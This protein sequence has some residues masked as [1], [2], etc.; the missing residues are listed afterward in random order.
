MR[1]ARA[2]RV[3]GA[4]RRSI[5][6]SLAALAAGCGPAIPPP[7][8]LPDLGPAPP[9]HQAVAAPAREP[10][11][12]DE[13]TTGNAEVQAML[14]RVSAARGL[15][16]RRQVTTRILDRDRI[17]DRI[18][19]KVEAE[20]PM[21]VLEHQGEVLAA[22]GL[23]PPEYDYVDG[24][25][26]LIQGR[27][28]GYYDPADDSMVLVDDLDEENAV[29]TLAHELVHALQDQAFGIDAMIKYRP[30]AGDEIAA[31]HSLIE[32]DATSAMFEVVLGSAF[33]V[34]DGA[35]RTILTASSAMSE[36]G[37]TPKVLQASLNAPYVDGFAFVQEL[38]RRGGWSTVD[39]AFKDPPRS[40]EQLLHVEKFAAR[41]PP[42]PIPPMAVTPLGGD[43][44]PVLDDVV[45]EQGLRITLEDWTSRAEALR[46]AAGWGGDRYV[47]ARRDGANGPTFA[48]GWLLRLD[49]TADASEVTRILER[50]HGKRC[51]VRA[52]LGPF[53]WRARGKD[54]AFVG[55]PYERRAKGA[56]PTP[57]GSCDQ[58]LR[59][60]EAMLKDAPR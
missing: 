6:A 20:I 17:L 3:R 19:K 16:V 38:R 8:P 53:A 34:S 59:W 44:R 22:Y 21:D 10:P 43:F 11:P 33:D 28:A 15:P 7:P 18:R 2:A 41:E 45:G 4:L 58:A 32:G 51:S 46:A 49:S 60:I 54:I 29:Q 55:G 39:G 57:A 48:V 24:A 13:P 36:V 5:A 52:Q 27:I 26:R 42:I 23:V 1:V 30:G 50:R 37:S 56:T 40:T 25:Y 31:A 12:V 14:S 9:S 35:L 47:V